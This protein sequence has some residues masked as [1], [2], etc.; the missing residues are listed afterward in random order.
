MYRDVG[1]RVAKEIGDP[2]T[3][4]V[5]K[6]GQAYGPSLRIRVN[7]DITNSLWGREIMQIKGVFKGWVYLDS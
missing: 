1:Y 4:D 7:V 2:I 3:V 5:P 6:S